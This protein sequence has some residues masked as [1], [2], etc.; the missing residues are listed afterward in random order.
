[1]NDRATLEMFKESGNRIRSMALVHEKLYQSADLSCLDFTDYV[2]SLTDLLVRSYQA[3]TSGVSLRATVEN[4]R[5]GIDAAVP[6]GLIINELVSN[7]LK[8]AYPPGRCGE[9]RVAIRPQD[10]DG[11]LLSVAD[12]GIGL[13][14]DFDPRTAGTLGMQLVCALTDQLGGAI[15]LV[16][17]PGT[18]F[19]IR[20]PR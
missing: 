14:A 19:R 4:V 1:V 18:E 3:E 9:V 7:S 20:F 17:Q 5:L 6:L 2:R 10:C 16:A 12:D 13:A 8:Y 15:E 11:Y